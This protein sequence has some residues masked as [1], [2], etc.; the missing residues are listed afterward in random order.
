MVSWT[1]DLLVIGLYFASK[2]PIILMYLMSSKSLEHTGCPILEGEKWI[3][4]VWM[5]QGVDYEHDW[6]GVDPSGERT[7]EEYYVDEA[8]KN[9]GSRHFEL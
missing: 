1:L 9:S 7:A 2:I 3:S 5:R 4:T 6:A 8:N